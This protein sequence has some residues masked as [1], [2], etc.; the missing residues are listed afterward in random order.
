MSE[1]KAVTW[2]D[3][4][5]EKNRH[6][7]AQFLCTFHV[8]SY[9]GIGLYLLIST[10]F[11]I[12]SIYFIRNEIFSS[13]L[14]I[15]AI[16]ILI[17]SFVHL[18][19]KLKSALFCQQEEKIIQEVNPIAMNK[20]LKQIHRLSNF[21]LDAY[22]YLFIKYSLFYISGALTTFFGILLL[23]R[24]ILLCVFIHIAI[25]CLT[26]LCCFISYKYTHYE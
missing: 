5:L 12:I 26:G 4:F 15:V 16:R 25:T 14:Y 19:S 22:T 7:L 6:F 11:L 24:K 3:I 8:S 20:L 2:E 18:P 10:I 17:F 13:L 9:K 21:L 1:K 23:L